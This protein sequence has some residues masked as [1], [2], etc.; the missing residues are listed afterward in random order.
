VLTK[1]LFGRP[2]R[3]FIE[4]KKHIRLIL[5]LMSAC[6][7]GIIG[8][9][10]FWNYQN[11]NNTIKAFDHD[12]NEALNTAVKRE[13]D[14]RR[15]HIVQQFEGWM[16]DT[17]LI[18]VTA[19]HNNRD[20]AT[21]FHTGDRHPRFK[22]DEKRVFTFG[23]SDF[24]QK[25]NHITPESKRYLIAHFGNTMV[26]HDLEQGTVYNYTQLLGDSLSKAFNSSNV[27]LPSLNRLFKQELIARGIK[28]GFVLNPVN[29]A[30]MFLTRPVN[31]DLRKPYKTTNVYAGFESPNAYFFKVMKWV[32][33][34]S[35]LLIVVT[36]GCFYY[37]ARTLLS[38]DKLARL[39]DDF[40]NNMTH[41][42]NTPLA[43]IK[44][45]AEALKSFDHT[46]ETRQEYLEIIAYQADKLTGM[47]AQILDSRKPIADIS[48]IGLHELLA[49]AIGELQPKIAQ[50]GAIVN[51][52]PAEVYVTGDG[53]GLLIAFVNIIDNALKYSVEKARLTITLQNS[54]KFA[55]II[56]ADN[57]LGIPA[58]YKEKIFEQFFRVP[59]GNRH[60]VKGYGLG[61]S[62]VSRIVKQ[63][64]G[65]ISVAANLPQGSVFS[66]QLPL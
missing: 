30:G 28:A 63:H 18:T 64:H 66:I 20:S 24:K 48:L 61:L 34:T 54:G 14:Q 47:A 42:L 3:I 57:G 26:K 23:L 33:I 27:N 6:V 38:Q 5:I 45:T 15:E 19:D 41:E 22:Q 50:E 39:K 49:Q 62:F 46:P 8:L 31:A 29:N 59:Q 11:Y 7:A 35:F 1:T 37:T 43:S 56:F 10:M 51:V 44:I 21:V 25:L 9:Q 65:K 12:I 53:A 17:S 52:K 4:M 36:V 2:C 40:I 60:N 32:I 16:A 13:A 58:E 55:E